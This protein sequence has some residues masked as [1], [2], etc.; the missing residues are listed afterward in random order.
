MLQLETSLI[1]GSIGLTTIN[2]GSDAVFIFTLFRNVVEYGHHPDFLTMLIVPFLINYLNSWIFWYRFDKRKQ[3]TW[4]ACVFNV[5]PQLRAANVIRELWRDPGR[6]ISE[7]KKFERELSEGEVFLESTFATFAMAFMLQ[8]SIYKSDDTS[9]ALVP[10]SPLFLVTFITSF[11][12]AALGMAK[13]LKAGPCRILS[14]DKGLLGGLLSVRF[15]L[16]FVACL[17]TLFGKV[18]FFAGVAHC[19]SFLISPRPLIASALAF[20][21]V[22]LPGLII[23]IIFIRHR[24]LLKTFLNHPSLLILPAFT[25]F[26][27]ESNAKCCSGNRDSQSE[28]EI[29]FSVRATCVNILFW[30]ATLIVYN[31]TGWS[32]MCSIIPPP[33]PLLI[34]LVGPLFTAIL[35]STT[36]S[37]FSTSCSPAPT[38]SCS[39]SCCPP[40]QFGIYLPDSPCRVFVK[41]QTQPDGRKEIKDKEEQEEQETTRETNE[42][43]KV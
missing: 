12:T 11:F 14:V 20:C 7:K 21:A 8:A 19:S 34:M 26:S 9:S 42:E 33:A 24:S 35:L 29:T 30:F 37:F 22:S 3:I 28:V 1:V 32:S 16:I 13:R 6:G 10:T 15:L 36:S 5:Y 39:N 25:F 38:S 17:A 41:D 27:F 23:G 18:V 4:L 40:L 2:V 43:E 31:L